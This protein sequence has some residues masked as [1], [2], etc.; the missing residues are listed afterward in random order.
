[1]ASLPEISETRALPRTGNAANHGITTAA[2]PPS[3]I[4]FRNILLDIRIPANHC[5][6]PPIHS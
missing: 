4:F 1:M 2:V 6:V 5:V 3:N